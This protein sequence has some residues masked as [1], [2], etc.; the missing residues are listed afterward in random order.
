MQGSNQNAGTCK[1][2]RAAKVIAYYGLRNPPYKLVS[3]FVSIKVTL[4]RE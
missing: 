3:L 1:N 2:R 4:G